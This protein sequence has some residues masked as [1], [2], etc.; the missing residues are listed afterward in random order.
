MYAFKK[1]E[2][3]LMRNNPDVTT[4]LIEDAFD[5]DDRF[6]TAESNFMMA[7]AFDN[8]KKT[9]EDPRYF[10]WI[11]KFR[12]VEGSKFERLVHPHPCVASDYAKFYPTGK[13]YEEKVDE[14][15]QSGSLFCIDWD[16]E[17]LELYGA[18]EGS[19]HY[20]QLEVM[21]VPCHMRESAMIE[22]YAEDSIRD[23]CI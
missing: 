11:A 20:S 6:K 19:K 2:T 12:T 13:K 17:N 15:I 21:A 1:F 7:F 10:K 22:S 5:S 4:N 9:D 18:K 14:L 23:D 8:G 16:K 3:L